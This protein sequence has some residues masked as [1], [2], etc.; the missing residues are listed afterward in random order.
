MPMFRFT[1]DVWR[2]VVAGAL[3]GIYVAQR[4]AVRSFNRLSSQVDTLADRVRLDYY[5][6]YADVQRDMLDSDERR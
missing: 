2:V 6:V 3:V 1:P 4:R 5:R